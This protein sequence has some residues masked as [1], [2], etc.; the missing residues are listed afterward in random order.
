MDTSERVVV[1]RALLRR[2][3]SVAEKRRI[4]E[5]TLEPGASILSDS[6]EGFEENLGS[7]FRSIVASISR[8]FRCGLLRAALA[9]ISALRDTP[10]FS[11]RILSAA[12]FKA[13]SVFVCHSSRRGS[14]YSV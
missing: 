10:L 4:V 13:G 14:V 9:S 8:F 2:R 7:T 12:F 1:K 5:E 6:P 11:T 3:R